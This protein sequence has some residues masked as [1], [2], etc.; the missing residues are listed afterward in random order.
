[1]LRTVALPSDLSF[2]KALSLMAGN[3]TCTSIGHIHNYIFLGSLLY[4]YLESM[5][6]CYMYFIFSLHAGYTG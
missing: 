5:G 2:G 3:C 6:S 1:M 4:S